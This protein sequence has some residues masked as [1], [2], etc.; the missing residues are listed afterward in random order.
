MAKIRRRPMADSGGRRTTKDQS[1][2]KDRQ[3][4]IHPL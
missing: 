1:F 4:G 3:S 2:D